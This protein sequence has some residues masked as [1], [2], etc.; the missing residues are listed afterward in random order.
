MRWTHLTQARANLMGR[1]RSVHLEQGA[2]DMKTDQ[3]P[4]GDEELVGIGWPNSDTCDVELKL[5]SHHTIK[6]FRFTWVS[7]LS[8]HLNLSALVG[9][10]W[11]AE[12][13]QKDNHRI[14]VRLDFAHDGAI[15][16]ECQDV[17][18]T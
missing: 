15:A 5:R 13:L 7:R 9:L 11:D 18:M 10:T 1:C 3:L 14:Q 12:F 4:R 8:I 6:T 2:K 17:S 16:F